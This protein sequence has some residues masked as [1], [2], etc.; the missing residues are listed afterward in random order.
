MKYFSSTKAYLESDWGSLGQGQRSN[1]D[2]GGGYCEAITMVQQLSVSETIAT[3]RQGTTRA[4]QRPLHQSAHKLV[5][6]EVHRVVI[7]PL[8]LAYNQF[9]STE[10][11]FCWRWQRAN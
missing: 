3:R 1:P 5:H 11:T 6:R 8:A 2:W 10:V 7:V 9:N 4:Q